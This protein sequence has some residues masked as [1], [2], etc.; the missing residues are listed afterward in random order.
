MSTQIDID[1]LLTVEDLDLMPDDGN[2]YEI[3]GPYPWSDSGLI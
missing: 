3:P 1:S 2:R